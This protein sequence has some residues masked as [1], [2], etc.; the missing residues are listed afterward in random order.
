MD[1]NTRIVALAALAILLFSAPAQARP[2]SAVG[3]T[4]V[5][6]ASEG[7]EYHAK[8]Q[9]TVARALSL[10][11]GY[12][13]LGL[14]EGT[15]NFG[16]AGAGL[17]LWRRN[18]AGSQTNIFATLGYG[19]ALI[20]GAD[21]DEVTHG[22]RWSLVFDAENR[23]FMGGFGTS[24]MVLANGAL[25][26]G[27]SGMLGAAPYVADYDSVQMW[28]MAS[29]SY[30][31]LRPETWSLTPHMRLMYRSALV[32]VGATVRGEPYVNIVAEF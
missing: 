31:P 13:R 32:E 15:T 2:V 22:G 3:T 29:A 24:G 23:H 1:G 9:Y 25:D 28:L 16:E 4:T 21:D 6:V 12:H 18:G 11:V 30:T 20:E 14:D 5:E 19:G 8:L 26:V 7:H 10:G 17:L 27:G